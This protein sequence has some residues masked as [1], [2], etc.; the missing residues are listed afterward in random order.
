MVERGGDVRLQVVDN[1]RKK[2]LQK[3]VREQVEAGAAIF[4]DELLSY[5]GLGNDFQH[6]VVNHAV[7]YADGMVHTNT[8]ENFWSL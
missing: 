5:D 4:T 8:L 6:Q 7:E 2:Q 1:R 3:Q